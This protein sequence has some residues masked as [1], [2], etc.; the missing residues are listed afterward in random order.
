MLAL[1]R[2]WDS[3]LATRSLKLT[4]DLC[5][6]VRSGALLF[7]L[8]AALRGEEESA[9]PHT[10]PSSADEQVANLT[11]FLYRMA[12][13]G[14]CLLLTDTSRRHDNGVK[15]MKRLVAALA[16]GERAAVVTISWSLI[17]HYE[18]IPGSSSSAR[19]AA[20]P[21]G[22]GG[23]GVRF[24]EMLAD[25]VA[26]TVLADLLSWLRHSTA[27]YAGVQV[28]KNRAAWSQCFADGRVFC[29]L[30]HAT[31]ARLLDYSSLDA[32]LE[33]ESRVSR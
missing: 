19:P 4:A 23:A 3:H 25:G 14:I 20:K 1:R 22:S 7:E 9:A 33:D 28:G 27:G 2:W 10:V 8:L 24:P 29:A 21:S 31:D 30:V 15:A 11:T 18:V 12:D 13:L 6:E 26:A 16:A 5:S 17:M 32:M